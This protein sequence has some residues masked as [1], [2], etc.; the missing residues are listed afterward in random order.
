VEWLI[1]LLR[2]GEF[3]NSNLSQETNNPHRDF[4]YFLSAPPGKFRKKN[5]IRTRPL[6]SITFPIHGLLNTRSFNAIYFELFI[7]TL[8]CY[9]RNTDD[10][11]VKQLTLK[12]ILMAAIQYSSIALINTLNIAVTTQQPTQVTSCCHLLSPVRQLFS[13][14]RSVMTSFSQVQRVFTVTIHLASRSTHLPE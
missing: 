5:I 8:R 1:I 6:P 10:R 3:P 7:M 2:T 4:M 13:H 11:K 14:S 9:T 12:Y